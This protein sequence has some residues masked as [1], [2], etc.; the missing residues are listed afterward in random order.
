M[1]YEGEKIAYPGPGEV[2]I[3]DALAERLG[4]AVGDTVTLRTNDMQ[5]LE[6]KVSAIFQNYVFYYVYVNSETCLD[7]WGYVPEYKTAYVNVTDGTDVRASAAKVMDMDG[8]AAV[9]VVED[10][11][12]RIVNMMSSLDYIV[13]LIVFCAAMLALIVLYNLTNINITER[14]REIA[15]IKVLGFYANETASY[16]FRENILLTAMGALIG[17]VLGKLLHL[18][19][20]N[21]IRIDMIS[22]DIRIEP[23]SMLFSLGLTFLFTLGVN[24]LM[25]IKLDKINMAESLKSIE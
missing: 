16:V 3:C 8:V 7:Q 2:A 22:F 11:R 13:L 4:I 14:V 15:T 24:L 6:V 23:L 17:L 19:V 9:T 18:Y 10:L 25:R 12:G 5:S 20:M 21:Q 1:H